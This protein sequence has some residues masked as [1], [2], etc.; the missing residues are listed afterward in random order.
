MAYERQISPTSID[1]LTSL[2]ALNG[3]ATLAF[4][5]DMPANEHNESRNSQGKY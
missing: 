5:N 2:P 1:E 4:V 3:N